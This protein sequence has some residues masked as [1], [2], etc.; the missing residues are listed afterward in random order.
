LGGGG[1]IGRMFSQ[2]FFS[3]QALRP[4][5][6]GPGGRVFFGQPTGTLAF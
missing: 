5:M 6:Q 1:V 3:Q 4:T 2:P